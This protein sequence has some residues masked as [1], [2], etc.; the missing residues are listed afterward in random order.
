MLTK[1]GLRGS[2]EFAAM[3]GCARIVQAESFDSTDCKAA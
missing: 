2:E 3:G 1:G